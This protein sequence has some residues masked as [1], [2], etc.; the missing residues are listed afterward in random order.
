MPAWV[1]KK[2]LA[3]LGKEAPTLAFHASVTNPFGKVG[4]SCYALHEAWSFMWDGACRVS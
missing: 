1:T 2:W 3:V 4:S